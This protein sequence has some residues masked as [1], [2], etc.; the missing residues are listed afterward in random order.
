MHLLPHEYIVSFA[1]RLLMLQITSSWQLSSIPHDIA[2]IPRHKKSAA[3][4]PLKLDR[5]AVYA[6]LLLTSQN[7][8]AS[9][10]RTEPRVWDSSEFSRGNS[11]NGHH[12]I[13]SCMFVP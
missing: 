13:I 1:V 10:K 3:F 11:I 8:S 4:C 12:F 9:S 7:F 6:V 5:T 2:F